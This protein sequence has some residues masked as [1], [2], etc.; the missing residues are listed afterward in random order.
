MPS[1]SKPLAVFVVEKI[2]WRQGLR[3]LSFLAAWG[4]AS[5]RVGHP[6][7]MQEYTDFW[8]QSLATSYKERDAFALV[9]PDE[10]KTPGVVWDKVKR[11]VKERDSRAVAAAEVLA[12]KW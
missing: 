6:V 12:V 4:I 8:G 2:G 7:T 5:E 1:Q 9:W 10:V 11:Q 3:A